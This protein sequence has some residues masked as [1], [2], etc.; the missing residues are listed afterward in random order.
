MDVLRLA[1]L[2]NRKREADLSIGGNG[3]FGKAFWN[4]EANGLKKNRSGYAGADA[5]SLG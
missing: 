2:V 5:R 4:G 3:V 1:F